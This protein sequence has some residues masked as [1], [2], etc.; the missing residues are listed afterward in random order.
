MIVLSESYIEFREETPNPKTEVISVR[1]KNSGV[2]L[3]LIK[4]FGSW[5]QYCFYPKDF[6]V[7]S[8]GCMKEIIDYIN[9]LME[10]RRN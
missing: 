6:T 1:S 9:N 4:W 3:G 7:F 5:R 2:I 10:K 8:R